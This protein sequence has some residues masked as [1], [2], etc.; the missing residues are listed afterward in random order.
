VREKE[1]EGERERE[2]VGARERTGVEVDTHPVANLTTGLL[3]IAC[4][5]DDGGAGTRQ[6]DGVALV[7]CICRRRRT[8]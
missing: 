3:A 6:V 7:V 4:T 1:R 8:A 2:R 5:L